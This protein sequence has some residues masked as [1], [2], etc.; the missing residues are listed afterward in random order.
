MGKFSWAMVQVLRRGVPGLWDLSR[1]G[2]PLTDQQTLALLQAPSLSTRL[3]MAAGVFAKSREVLRQ[4]RR[5]KDLLEN[6]ATG[7]E[8]S[9]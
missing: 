5:L 3:E 6:R 9:E 1:D 8:P 2:E 4:H 7:G